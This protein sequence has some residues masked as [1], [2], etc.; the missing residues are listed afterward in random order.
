MG[1]I[2]PPLTVAASAAIP[3]AGSTTLTI[4]AAPGVGFAI[5]VVGA[6][7]SVNRAAGAVC[8]CTLRDASG[9]AIGLANG[10]NVAGGS[11]AP[12]DI[13]EPGI[14]A[15]ANNAVQLVGTST[16]GAGTFAALIYYYIDPV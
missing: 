2:R 15:T 6:Q 7:I 12:I 4:L 14:Q 8:D 11:F 5:R 1:Y 16:A 3:G 10:L 9:V 13:P